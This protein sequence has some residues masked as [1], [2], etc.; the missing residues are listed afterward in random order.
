MN[1]DDLLNDVIDVRDLIARFEELENEW[2]DVVGEPSDEA[3]EWMQ[4]NGAEY[5]ILKDLLEELAGHGGDEQWRGAWYP[6]TLV[7]A[8]YFTSYCKELCE[9]IGDIP[10][11]L[12]HYIE[13]D[14]EGTAQNIKVDYV[15]VTIDGRD[16]LYR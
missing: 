9:D 8:D 5:K 1:I 7:S 6:I 14:W 16:Y 11:D 2:N 10:R 3:V 12:P 4:D 13:I 15:E